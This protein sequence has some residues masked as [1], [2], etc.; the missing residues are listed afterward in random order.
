MGVKHFA[1]N[2]DIIVHVVV[3]VKVDI[4]PEWNQAR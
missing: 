2:F 4:T 1:V 3:D